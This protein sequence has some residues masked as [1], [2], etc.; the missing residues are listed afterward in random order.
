MAAAPTT[1]RRCPNLSFRPP[2]APPPAAS[3]SSTP[4]PR[5]GGMRDG[6]PSAAAEGD[7]TVTRER[8][9]MG[10]GGLW[11]T[12]GWQMLAHCTS[13][14]SCGKWQV[15]MCCSPHPSADTP[16]PPRTEQALKHPLVQLWDFGAPFAFWGAQFAPPPAPDSCGRAWPA[17]HPQPG[18][19]EGTWEPCLTLPLGGSSSRLQRTTGAKSHRAA[20]SVSPQPHRWLRRG[21]RGTRG[22]PPVPGV[23]PMTLPSTTGGVLL[24]GGA[25]GVVVG[26]KRTLKS[27]NWDVGC[28]SSDSVSNA[29]PP[30]PP[31]PLLPM[32]SSAGILWTSPSKTAFY[33]FDAGPA[34]RH[35]GP[36]GRGEQQ[37]AGRDGEEGRGG[38]KDWP[39]GHAMSCQGSPAVPRGLSAPRKPCLGVPVERPR[40]SS[41]FPGASASIRCASGLWLPHT[42]PP[43]RTLL[44]RV[45]PRGCPG[46]ATT[47]PAPCRGGRSTS[48]LLSPLAR[49]WGVGAA[50]PKPLGEGIGAGMGEDTCGQPLVPHGQQHAPPPCHPGH[51]PCPV[52]PCPNAASP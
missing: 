16:P 27:Q 39:C 35:P 49:G 38:P 33:I 36:Q 31:P 25:S 15:R 23:V 8:Q 45:T 46:G 44:P 37:G 7:L 42:S 10:R 14:S 2:G 28:R 30:P 21:L 22:C 48:P 52:S 5:Q 9:D 32:A 1:P 34:K 17:L 24:V 50:D 19:W 18:G 26:G 12:K 3:L 6:R 20:G 47:L 11:G 43:P 29:T 40:R 4:S 13:S 51:C 41:S